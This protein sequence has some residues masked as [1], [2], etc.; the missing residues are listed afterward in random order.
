MGSMGESGMS[1]TADLDYL[2][3]ELEC[4]LCGSG[5]GEGDV[6]LHLLLPGGHIGTR[7]PV[8]ILIGVLCTISLIGSWLSF[9]LSI[10]LAAAA[11]F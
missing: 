11:L 6:G 10:L 9:S 5:D 8:S 4:C 1:F 3:L 2:F 7:P